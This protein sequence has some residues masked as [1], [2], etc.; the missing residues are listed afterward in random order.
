MYAPQMMI[1]CR[2]FFKDPRD[3]KERMQDGFVKFFKHIRE[4]FVFISEEATKGWLSKIMVY[5]CINNLK[6]KSMLVA[7][8]EHVENIP[9]EFDGLENMRFNEM[10]KVINELPPG[11]RVIFNLH[12]F[13]GMKHRE[14]AQALNITKGTCHSQLAKAKTYLK[15]LLIKKGFRDEIQNK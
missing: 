10:L 6:K 1:L 7:L 2:R 15:Q 9:F 4:D 11:Y 5:E 14:I 13:E 3:A 12:E 8:D